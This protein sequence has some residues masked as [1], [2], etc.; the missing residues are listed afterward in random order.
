MTGN[1]ILLGG[2]IVFFQSLCLLGYCLFPLCVS[3][4]FCT[5]FKQVVSV[6]THKGHMDHQLVV[7]G[8]GQP[9]VYLHLASLPQWVRCLSLAVGLGWASWATVPFIGNAVPDG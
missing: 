9:S 2:D 1:V 6:E 8:C 3:A 7:P 5:A 4:F